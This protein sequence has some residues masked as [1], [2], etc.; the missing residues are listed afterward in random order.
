MIT[1]VVLVVAAAVLV[2][3]AIMVGRHIQSQERPTTRRSKPRFS[4]RPS[5]CAGHGLPRI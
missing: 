2:L 5:A 4:L 1:A 3:T